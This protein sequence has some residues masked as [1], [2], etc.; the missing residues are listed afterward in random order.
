MAPSAQVWNLARSI[1][2]QRSHRLDGRKK[3]PF[4]HCV[5]LLHAGHQE[6]EIRLLAISRHRQIR[7]I[8]ATLESIY[9]PGEVA[10]LLRGDG[11]E[12]RIKLQLLDRAVINSEAVL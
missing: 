2:L 1:L 12:L 8:P 6:D 5:V 4:V 3:E 11:L 10:D 7:E 9:V